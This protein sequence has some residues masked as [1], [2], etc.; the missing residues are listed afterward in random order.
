MSG[1]IYRLRRVCG[2]RACGNR[3]NRFAYTLYNDV[4]GSMTGVSHPNKNSKKVFVHFDSKNDA[5]NAETIIASVIEQHSDTGLKSHNLFTN[6]AP[7]KLV[8][9][10]DSPSKAAWTAQ[11]IL[12][13]MKGDSID[14]THIGDN[15]LVKTAK[16]LWVKVDMVQKGDETSPDE[17]NFNNDNKD[18]RRD[19]KN[20]SDTSGNNTINVQEEGGSSWTTWALIGGGV[21]LLVIVV[22][23]FLKKKK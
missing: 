4:A 21:L 12:Q 3:V 1:R 2:N 14:K 9:E 10:F 7:W 16:D 11:N 19:N 18:S 8:F 6:S 17:Q 23:M 13:K 22:A 5:T 15:G 20:D